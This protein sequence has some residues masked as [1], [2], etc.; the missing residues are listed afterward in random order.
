MT[1]DIMSSIEERP[2]LTQQ[3]N[4]EIRLG[5]ARK[6]EDSDTY[7]LPDRMKEQIDDWRLWISTY[8]YPDNGF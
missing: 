6:L 2:N 1:P 4:E 8:I 7:S 5:L 3:V